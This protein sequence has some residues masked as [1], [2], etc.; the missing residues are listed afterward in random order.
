[1]SL[2]TRHPSLKPKLKINTVSVKLIFSNICLFQINILDYDLVFIPVLLPCHRA[3]GVRLALF[4]QI[5]SSQYQ[6]LRI[7]L[8]S[9]FFPALDFSLCERAAKRRERKIFFP[10]TSR[11]SHAGKN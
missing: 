10:A 5:K 6:Y 8:C 1:M 2:Q 11:L 9:V 3:L 7:I 4:N